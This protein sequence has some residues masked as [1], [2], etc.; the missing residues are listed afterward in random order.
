MKVARFVL[1]R[2]GGSNSAP[3]FDL[4]NPYT[5]LKGGMK[6]VKPTNGVDGTGSLKKQMPSCNGQD[7]GQYLSLKGR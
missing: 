7:R 4:G 5:L 6:V 3:L 2:G 1:R